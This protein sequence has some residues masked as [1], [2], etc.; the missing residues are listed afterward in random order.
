MTH[1]QIQRGQ[2]QLLTTTVMKPM[3][4]LEILLEC[5]SQ[6]LHGVAL[7]QSVEVSIVH[8]LLHAYMYICSVWLILLFCLI[9]LTLETC[10]ELPALLHGTINYE[11]KPKNSLSRKLPRTVATYTC[12]KEYSL[13]VHE[14]EKRVCQQSGQWSGVAPVCVG[15]TKHS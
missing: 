13:S 8:V 12:N 4:L 7:S 15:K 10:G 9:M 1:L 2:T 14:N 11:Y 5:V 6:T 3:L